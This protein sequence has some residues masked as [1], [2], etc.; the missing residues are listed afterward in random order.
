MCSLMTLRV[1][2]STWLSWLSLLS[3]PRAAAGEP[4]L[5]VLSLA[6]GSGLA[7]LS[8]RV[9]SGSSIVGSAFGCG[10]SGGSAKVGTELAVPIVGDSCATSARGVRGFEG[11]KPAV[12][13]GFGA[14]GAEAAGATRV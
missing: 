4:L 6:V 13:P 5:L 14:A 7:E 10:G 12:G 1:S 11:V 2:F 3:R 9:T 8:G